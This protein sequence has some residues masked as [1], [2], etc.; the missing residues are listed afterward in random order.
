MVAAL[1][2]LL[3]VLTIVAAVLIFRQGTEYRRLITESIAKYQGILNAFIE[4]KNHQVQ[5]MGNRIAEVITQ[6]KTDLESAKGAHKARIE[7]EIADLEKLK[8]SLKPQTPPARSSG[9]AFPGYMEGAGFSFPSSSI[10]SILWPSTQSVHFTKSHTCTKC[11]HRYDVPPLNLGTIYVG[12]RPV[13]CPKCGNVD[14][15]YS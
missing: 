4:E 2:V 1:A 6:A 10:S 12:G 5:L 9:P 3:G 14:H 13:T 8:E 15:V 11:G 7:K